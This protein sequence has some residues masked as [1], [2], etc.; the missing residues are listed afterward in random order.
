MEDLT[1]DRPWANSHEANEAIARLRK[2][3]TDIHVEDGEDYD[4]RRL[5][6]LSGKLGDLLA[7]ANRLPESIQAYQEATDAY[8]KLPDAAGLAEH[9]AKKVVSGVN[10]LR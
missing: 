10:Q 1:N 4:W 7:E 9:F 5:A 6:E 2:L 3:V 8:G